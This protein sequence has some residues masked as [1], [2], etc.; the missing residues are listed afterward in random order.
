MTSGYPGTA[1]QKALAEQTDTSLCQDPTSALLLPTILAVRLLLR[2][3]GS[4]LAVNA[5]ICSCNDIIEAS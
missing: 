4:H 1:S 2:A 5:A 3:S